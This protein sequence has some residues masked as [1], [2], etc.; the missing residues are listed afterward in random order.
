MTLTLDSSVFVA[1]FVKAESASD[2]ASKLLKEAIRD[3]MEVIIP[4][5]VLIESTL[6]V[7]RRVGQELAEEMQ[8]FIL[9]LPNLKLVEID[10]DAG[11]QII[12]LGSRLK[13]KGM[14]AIVVYVASEFDSALATLDQEMIEKSN[15]EITIYSWDK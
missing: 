14:D 1:A 3:R 7:A 5:T 11:L 10:F 2:K 6:A 13:L 4:M 9:D 8:E 15:S 12:E